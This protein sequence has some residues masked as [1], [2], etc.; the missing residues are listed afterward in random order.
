MDRKITSIILND[1]ESQGSLL[2]CLNCPWMFAG[3]VRSTSFQSQIIQAKRSK[4][5]ATVVK[6]SGVE[7]LA[8]LPLD[9]EDFIGIHFFCFIFFVSH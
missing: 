4:R 1:Q 3:A 2:V 9:T 6:L 5:A 8:A 7:E